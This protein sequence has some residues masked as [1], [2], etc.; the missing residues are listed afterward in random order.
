[1]QNQTLMRIL[2]SAWYACK[3]VLLLVRFIVMSVLVFA[4]YMGGCFTIM[5]LIACVLEALFGGGL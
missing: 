4:F 5:I 3:G 2:D 1:M